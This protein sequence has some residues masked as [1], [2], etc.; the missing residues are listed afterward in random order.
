[1]LFCPNVG[2]YIFSQ[3][4]RSSK[5]WPS[6]CVNSYKLSDLTIDRGILMAEEYTKIQF[7]FTLIIPLIFLMSFR[8]HAQNVIFPDTIRACNADSLLLDAGPDYD[9]YTWSTGDTGPL[10]WVFAS[11]DYS[12]NVTQGDTV[13]LTDEF[14]VVLVPA[15]IQQH[16]TSI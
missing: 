12:L 4:P 15:G 1:M 11:G 2:K 16:D 10:T 7:F 13:D 14:Y 3:F 6:L 8:G 9:T 5:F